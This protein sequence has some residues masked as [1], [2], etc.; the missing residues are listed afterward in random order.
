MADTVGDLNP[1]TLRTYAAIFA[2]PRRDLETD[3]VHPAGEA[4]EAAVACLLEI[5]R[6]NEVSHGRR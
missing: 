6:Q 2:M 1:E 4:C 5:A 3:A